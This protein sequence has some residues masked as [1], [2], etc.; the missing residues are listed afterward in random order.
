MTEDLLLFYKETLK[1]EDKIAMAHS[2][3]SHSATKFL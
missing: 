3:E 1:R 2:I